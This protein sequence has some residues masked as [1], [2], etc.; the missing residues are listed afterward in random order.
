MCL[1]FLYNFYLKHFSLQEEF[2]EISSKM[3]KHIRVMYPLFLSGFDETWIF[4]TYFRQ[5]AQISNVIKICVVGVELFHA[6]GR[7]DMT[8]LVVTFRNFGKAPETFQSNVVFLASGRRAS[9][10]RNVCT[11][12]IMSSQLWEAHISL[13][14]SMV[15][16]LFVLNLLTGVS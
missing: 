8:K 1:D 4:S 3:W 7:T 2:N 11:D 13:S 5:K 9:G 6:D 15:V 16:C 10:L 12:S 14:L